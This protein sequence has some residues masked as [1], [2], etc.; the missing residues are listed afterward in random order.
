[1]QLR[2]GKQFSSAILSVLA[3][4]A[5]VAALAK[6]TP[7]EPVVLAAGWQL[8]DGAK[9]PQTGAQV[10]VGGFQH[11]RM[12]C[13]YGARNRAYDAGQ[14]STSIPSRSMEKTTAP[15]SFPR[16]WRAPPTGTGQSIKV[17]RSYKNRH[18]WLNFDG[19]NYSADV[20][21]NGTQVGTM[22]GAFIRGI[23]DITALVKPGKRPSSPCSITPQPHPGIPHEH[24]L[25]DG[26]GQNGGDERDRRTHLPLH[27]GLGLDARYPRPRHRHLA[28]GLSLR[29]RPRGC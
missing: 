14:Q 3:V 29:N 18:V 12:V 22:R 7:P 5:P 26:V 17:P 25:R 16:V 15:R 8:Q 6:S 24:T 27:A 19:I 13:G 1:M 9:V 10:A 2:I 28:K 20:W 23:F 21:V 11:Q 4:L